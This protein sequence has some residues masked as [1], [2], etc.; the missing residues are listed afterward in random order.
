MRVY[1]LCMNG[2]PF[3]N[4]T[5]AAFST[6]IF[7]LKAK[8][9]S[10]SEPGLFSRPLHSFRTTGGEASGIE[11]FFPTTNSDRRPIEG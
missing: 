10:R 9:A 1:K 11:S 6:Y 7:L 4:S 5:V 8:F 3:G 2:M